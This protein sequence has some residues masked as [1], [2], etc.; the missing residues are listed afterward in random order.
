MPPPGGLFIFSPNEKSGRLQPKAALNMH[1]NNTEIKLL[2]LTH[3]FKR[4]E[5]MASE[6]SANRAVVTVLGSD[7][8]GI[9]AAI[10]TTLAESNA[11][12]LDIA[13]TILSGIFTMTMLV[14]L[15]DAESFLSLKERLD[16]VSEKLGVQVNMQREEVFTFMYR[17]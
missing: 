14:E 6:T 13:Q 2:Q 16:A 5:N 11:N 10:S 3:P 4:W 8:P 1:I 9:V 7:A 17:P 12:I 15:K